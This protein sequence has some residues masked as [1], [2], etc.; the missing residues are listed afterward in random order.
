MTSPTF[1]PIVGDGFEPRLRGSFSGILA[2]PVDRYHFGGLYVLSGGAI[3][4]AER[5]IGGP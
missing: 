2:V 4:R 3:Y 5:R 1:Y